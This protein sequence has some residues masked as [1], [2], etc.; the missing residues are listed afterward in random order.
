[1]PMPLRVAYLSKGK[2][3]VVAEDGSTRVYESRFG[4]SIRERAVQISHRHAW[5]SQG[6]GA[7]FMTG[8]MLLEAGNPDPAA[9]R[10]AIRGISAGRAAGEL[11]YALETNEVAGLFALKADGGEE[12]RLFHSADSRLQHLAAAPARDGIA[13]SVRRET[14]ISNI[15][16]MRADGSDL[17]D[18]TE[19]DSIDLAPSWVPGEGRRLVYQ[20]AGIG[21]DRDGA[22][23]GI[24]PSS[25]Q[26]LDLDH[27][28]VES[29]VEEEGSDLL[30]P[31]VAPDGALLFIRRP[32]EKPRV[33]GSFFRAIL[34]FILFPIRLLFALFQW[35][36]F[37]ATRYTGKPLT[38]AGGPKRK[39]ADVHQMMVWGNLVDAKK[40]ALTAL[41]EDGEPPDLVPPTWQLVR[42]SEAGETAVLGKGVLSF[43]LAPDGTA[44]YS[45]GSAVFHLLADGSRRRICK[46]E[47]IEQVVVVP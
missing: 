39:G 9:I 35:V 23:I 13:C 15:A 41:G 17:V 7:R 16:M 3:H 2:V 12:Q 42:R 1:M 30:G 4:Q 33:R 19:G 22:A 27:G 43:D 29:L 14:G 47:Q 36:N 21:R 11:L 32:Y 37:F 24:G 18:I 34:D 31:R 10:V 26:R 38:T 20:S 5:K 28:N 46:G 8:G 44:V 6:R 45:N 40:G 25:I